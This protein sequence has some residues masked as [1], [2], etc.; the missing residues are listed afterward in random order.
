[1]PFAPWRY[2]ENIAGLIAVLGAV[3]FILLA[4]YKKTIDNHAPQ[5]AYF[6]AG[7]SLVIVDALLA[8]ALA[9]LLRPRRQPRQSGWQQQNLTSRL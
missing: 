3:S 7:I 2:Q 8:V 4:R 6:F 1:M 9:I 5:D